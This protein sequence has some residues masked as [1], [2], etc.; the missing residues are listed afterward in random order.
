MAPGQADAHGRETVADDHGVG[1]V[2]LEE[3]RRPD[4]VGADVA[5]DDVLRAQRPAQVEDRLL[6]LDRPAIVRLVGV[7]LAEDGLA[8]AEM[9]VVPGAGLDHR[10]GR[11][12]PGDAA[13][14][15][16]DQLDVRLVAGVDLGR[17][18]VDRHDPLG[19]VR[20]PAVGRVLDRVVADADDEVRPIE[21]GQ[22]VIA[23]LE[24]DGHQRELVPV[25]DGALAHEG[26]GH[27]DLELVREHDAAPSDALRRR[28]PLPA[29]MSG[30]SEA[31]TRRAAWAIA[32][33]VGS[34]K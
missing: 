15:V 2:R 34:G 17:L 8:Q 23:S 28:T 27:R 3:P 20:V 11:P 16:A 10:Q 25:V 18:R 29:R 14:D 5:D 12:E 22:D 1:L 32:S 4:L 33:S 30:R 31:A 7:Q 6:R 19:S 21:A 26:D 13:V 24:A 9:V